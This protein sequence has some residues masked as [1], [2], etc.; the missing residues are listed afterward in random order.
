LRDT[1]GAVW[2]SRR[3][4]EADDGAVTTISVG[5]SPLESG[6]RVMVYVPGSV[7]EVDGSGYSIDTTEARFQRVSL[8]SG[9]AAE[10]RIVPAIA[11]SR[12]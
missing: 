7:V 1:P 11:K 4:T 5:P 9:A 6:G 3:T 10:I 12:P 8:E 2:G